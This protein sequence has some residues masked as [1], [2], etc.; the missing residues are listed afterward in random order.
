ME[1]G[2]MLVERIYGNRRSAWNLFRGVLAAGLVSFILLLILAFVMLKLQMDVGQ[3]EIGILATYA[4]SCLA[5]G[6]YCG[7]KS[8]RR[9]FI[10][11]LF[12]GILYFLLL[13]LIS[14]TG[15]DAGAADFM[16]SLTAFALCAAGGMLGGMLAG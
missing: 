12:T 15:E 13:F 3:M 7:R 6:W 4:L 16:Q 11:G 5:G 9:K 14:R 2:G 10:W 1:K 8:D